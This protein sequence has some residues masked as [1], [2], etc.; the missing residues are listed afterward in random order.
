M[1]A[2]ACKILSTNRAHYTNRGVQ[3]VQLVRLWP[4][5]TT[6]NCSDCMRV[7]L[8]SRYHLEFMLLCASGVHRPSPSI[9]KY[10]IDEAK[11][12]NVEMSWTFLFFIL[13]I[14]FLLSFYSQ[15]HYIMLVKP[16]TSYWSQPCI[17]K[18]LQSVDYDYEP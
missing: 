17:E 4:A 14:N 15:W 16:L 6:F 9:R 13:Q 1:K 5:G 7:D 10:V 11:L 3:T 2:C 8:D 12:C 18:D